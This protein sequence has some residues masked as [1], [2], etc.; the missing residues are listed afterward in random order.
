MVSIIPQEMAVNKGILRVGGGL[1]T[2]L[3]MLS[4]D[5]LKRGPFILGPIKTTQEVALLPNPFL[6]PEEVEGG[7]VVFHR[8]V[9]ESEERALRKLGQPFTLSPTDRFSELQL[10]QDAETTVRKASLEFDP[11][12]RAAL[13][14][15]N[16]MRIL[17]KPLAV[18]LGFRLQG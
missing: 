3:M 6:G 18:I 16:I 15:E 4:S 1:T 14:E 9:G 10:V 5:A 2:C 13:D 11:L 8:V 17:S 12:F 7:N